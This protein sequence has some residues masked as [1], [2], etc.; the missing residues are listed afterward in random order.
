LEE[1]STSLK[2]AYDY[3]EAEKELPVVMVNKQGKYIIQ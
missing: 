1:F 2:T 3:F